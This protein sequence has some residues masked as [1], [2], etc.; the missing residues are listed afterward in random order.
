MIKWM[1][2]Q[3]D[4]SLSEQLLLR[5]RLLF[6]TQSSRGVPGAPQQQQPQ[7]QQPQQQ[8]QQAVS[9]EAQVV[10]SLFFLCGWS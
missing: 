5:K 7:Q 3:L 2:V 4:S 8:Q 6:L 9:Q 1:K 10:P